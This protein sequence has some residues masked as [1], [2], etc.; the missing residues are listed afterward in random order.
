M[1]VVGACL[2]SRTR[3]CEFGRGESRA[4][5]A[6]CGSPAGSPAGRPAG[7]P[8]VGDEGQGG[9]RGGVTG[10]EEAWWAGP[11]AAWKTGAAAVGAGGRALGIGGWSWGRM[12]GCLWWGAFGAW[13][14]ARARRIS[15][16]SSTL[17]RPISSKAWVLV[18][19]SK[20]ARM[21]WRHLSRSELAVYWSAA[22]KM[23]AALSTEMEASIFDSHMR[24]RR[25]TPKRS[26]AWKRS[27]ARSRWMSR[28]SV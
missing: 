16:T 9:G 4:G 18:T 17:V 21:K 5:G 19:A 14:V 15:K 6:L 24:L 22:W 13:C 25:S 27:M 23:V 28:Q 20:L 26:A 3:W 12:V 11:A 8:S 7:R 2:A 1:R 10:M